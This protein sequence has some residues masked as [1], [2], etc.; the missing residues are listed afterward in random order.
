MMSPNMSSE[1]AASGFGLGPEICSSL[2]QRSAGPQTVAGSRPVT[3]A[4]ASTASAPVAIDTPGPLWQALKGLAANSNLQ[5]V[6]NSRV[7][8]TRHVCHHEP[9]MQS[10]QQS[11]GCQQVVRRLSHAAARLTARRLCHGP[12]AAGIPCQ[13]NTR[14]V[15]RPRLIYRVAAETPRRQR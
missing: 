7:V 6:V 1:S 12:M 10:S 8:T 13:P 9:E 5:Q 2:S 3:W 15:S 14:C 4:I 11:I